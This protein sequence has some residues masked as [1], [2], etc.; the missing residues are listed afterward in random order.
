[1]TAIG[2]ANIE[3]LAYLYY[4]SVEQYHAMIDAGIFGEDDPVELPRPT[5]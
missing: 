5:G 1:M 3:L 2:D 4:L